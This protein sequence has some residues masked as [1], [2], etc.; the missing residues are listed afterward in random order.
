MDKVVFLGLFVGIVGI[1]IALVSMPMD[2]ANYWPA[3][4]L[5]SAIVAGCSFIAAAMSLPAKKKE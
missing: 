2:G 5:S 1:I 3:V 4:L